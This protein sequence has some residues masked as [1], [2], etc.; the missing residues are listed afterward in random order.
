MSTDWVRASP[1]GL[2]NISYHQLNENKESLCE[3]KNGYA[4]GKHM[5]LY[6]HNPL[7]LHL[8]ASLT[9]GGGGLW[10]WR[11]CEREHDSGGNHSASAL[12]YPRVHSRRIQVRSHTRKHTSSVFLSSECFMQQL[13]GCFARST[14]VEREEH[15]SQLHKVN[16][17]EQF[18][19]V[20]SSLTKNVFSLNMVKLNL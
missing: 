11:A 7:C 13:L 4:R 15:K 6:S 1:L 18:W 5:G 9:A 16:T 2:V 8:H 3:P 20:H 10:S 17:F 12:C 19:M 14:S